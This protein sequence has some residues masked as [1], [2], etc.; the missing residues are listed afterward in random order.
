MRGKVIDGRTVIL[1]W[2][3]ETVE[4]ALIGH[5]GGNLDPWEF[6]FRYDSDFSKAL[7]SWLSQVAEDV[8]E[9]WT[10]WGD[11]ENP[12]EARVVGLMFESESVSYPPGN[13]EWLPNIDQIEKLFDI[14]SKDYKMPPASFFVSESG[15]CGAC[16][17]F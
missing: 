11:P 2:E 1:G 16:V 17:Q 4:D 7:D 5:L 9:I 14:L 10:G 3:F 6:P 12:E 15:A 8:E 13:G